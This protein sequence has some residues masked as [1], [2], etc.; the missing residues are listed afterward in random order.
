MF[1]VEINN[2]DK[3]TDFTKYPFVVARLTDG[4]FWFWGAFET[5]EKANKCLNEFENGAVFE[6]TI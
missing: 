4:K 1:K 6:Y 5:K 3:N 2:L